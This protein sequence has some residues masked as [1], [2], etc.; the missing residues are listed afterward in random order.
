MTVKEIRTLIDGT[1]YHF[2]T[3]HD[4]TGIHD[5]HVEKHNSLIKGNVKLVATNKTRTKWNVFKIEDNSNPPL[6]I[7]ARD[8]SLEEAMKLGNELNE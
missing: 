3:H 6:K 2:E 8:L 4:F 1:G 7:V 5:K